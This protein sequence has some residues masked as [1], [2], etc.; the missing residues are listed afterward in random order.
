[1][2]VRDAAPRLSNSLARAARA[3]TARV[4]QVLRPRGVTFDQW[5]VM[6]ALAAEGGL[7]MSDLTTRTLATGPTLTRVVDRL[8]TAAAAYRE[9]DL[10]D[11]RRVRVHL[12]SRG[13]AQHRRLAELVGEV[14]EEVLHGLG[15][16]GEV[17]TALG[18]LGDS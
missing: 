18:R 8:V 14:E 11:R 3:V 4:E 13:R 15:R 7:T 16:P 17:L 2:E 9:V 1:M 12:S 5:L 10:D 6:D